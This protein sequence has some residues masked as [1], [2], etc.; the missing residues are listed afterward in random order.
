MSP[1]A[2]GGF[3]ELSPRKQS[4]E[5]RNLKYE[6]YKPVEFLWNVTMSSLSAQTENPPIENFWQRFWVQS[7]GINWKL[8]VMSSKE[9]ERSKRIYNQ[10]TDKDGKVTVVCIK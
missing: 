7:E 9:P 4:F 1:V 2:T 8:S 10:R 6:H 5:T 3:G